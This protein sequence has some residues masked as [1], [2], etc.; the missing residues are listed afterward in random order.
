MAGGDRPLFARIKRAIELP[1]VGPLLYWANVKPFVVRM[2]VAGH[3]F[4]DPR[5][6]SGE[7]LAEKRR[8]ICA[9]GARFGSPPARTCHSVARRGRLTRVDAGRF[10]TEE[11]TTRL[12]KI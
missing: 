2:M 1:M 4:S 9:A 8:V 12:V 7:R 5:A 3:V 6:L 11:S 10:A